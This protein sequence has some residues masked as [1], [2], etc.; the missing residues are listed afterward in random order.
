MQRCSSTVLPYTQAMASPNSPQP[1]RITACNPF[2]GRRPRSHNRFYIRLP[3][4][5]ALPIGH[6]PIQNLPLATAIRPEPQ[7]DQQHDLF[8]LA[9]LALA[10]ALVQRDGVRLGLLAQPNA[11][12]L[13]HGRHIDDRFTVGELSQRLYLIDALVD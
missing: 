6:L 10:S 5:F 3:R 4:R 1:S 2:S 8:P 9:L 7:R 11:I 13:H 12:E